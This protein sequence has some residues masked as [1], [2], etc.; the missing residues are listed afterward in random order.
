MKMCHEWPIACTYYYS[1]IIACGRKE[2]YRRRH[3]LKLADMIWTGSLSGDSQAGR[4][5]PAGL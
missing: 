3:H 1:Y 2:L 4:H 5:W